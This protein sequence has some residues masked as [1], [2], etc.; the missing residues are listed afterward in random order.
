MPQSIDRRGGPIAPGT[1][2]AIVLE[3]DGRITHRDFASLDDARRYA[4]DAAWEAEDG[5]VYAHVVDDAY[6]IVHRGAR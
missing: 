2:R 5:P 1:Y 3:A 6:R 4:D